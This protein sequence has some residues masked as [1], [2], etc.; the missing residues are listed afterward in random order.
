MVVR[1]AH[2]HIHTHTPC[3]HTY[4][5]IIVRGQSKAP[6][7]VIYGIYTTQRRLQG[8]YCWVRGVYFNCKGVYCWV[9]GVFN[10]KGVYCWLRGVFNHKGVYCWVRGVYLA[11]HNC[12]TE[13]RFVLQWTGQFPP[14]LTIAYRRVL[15]STIETCIHEHNGQSIVKIFQVIRTAI[16]CLLNS[17][18]EPHMAGQEVYIA[19]HTTLD[20]GH[21]KFAVDIPLTSGLWYIYC[22]LP[23]TSVSGSIWWHLLTMV[24]I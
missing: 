24:Y 13:K 14:V 1:W 6:Q 16:Q 2:T 12:S 8:V 19:D 11:I 7:A 22:K 3:T 4:T 18:V 21:R 10:C 20:F 9:R 5:H 15:A 17:C 23:L